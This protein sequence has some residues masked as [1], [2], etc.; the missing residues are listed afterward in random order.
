M[1]L[2]SLLAYLHISAILGLAVFL[3][4]RVAL[5]RPEVLEQRPALLRRLLR[6]DLWCW[7]AF[8]AVALSGAARVLLGV[9][10]AGWYLHNPLLWTKLVLFAAMVL[11]GLPSSRACRRWVDLGQAPEPEI[12][13][14]RKWLMWQAH[15]MVLLPL[16]GALMAYG[17]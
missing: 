4:A 7:G 10:G 5:L 9:K 15:V 13:V 14:Q 8:A 6:L 16:F 3:T 11:M 17:Y 12:A 2:E 1:I